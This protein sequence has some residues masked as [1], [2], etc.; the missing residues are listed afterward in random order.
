M[1]YT[2]LYLLV[3]NVERSVATMLPVGTD[4]R[5][6]KKKIESQLFYFHRLFSH[7]EFYKEKRNV[8]P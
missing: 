5:V 1:N 4:A 2:L 7:Y 3:N 6:K 8:I